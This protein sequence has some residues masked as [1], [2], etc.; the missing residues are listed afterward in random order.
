MQL[1]GS[2]AVLLYAAAEALAIRALFRPRG[3][4]GAPALVAAGLLAQFGHLELAARSLKSVPYRT[5]GGSMALFGW[6]LGIAYLVLVFRHRER[7]VGPFLIPFVLAFSILGVLLPSHPAPATSATRGSLF[8]FHVT[9]AILAYAAF[10]LS[11]V[12]SML[13]LI[14]NRQIRRGRTGVLFSRLPALEVI[15]KMNRTSVTIGILVLS[16]S[17]ALGVAW[18]HR[19]WTGLV[20]AKLVWA[21]ITLFVYGLLLWMDRRGWEGPRVALLSIVG[22]ILVLFSYTF[23]NLYLSQSHVFR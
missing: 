5:L 11:F 3:L 18:A 13:Y 21:L 12:L 17:V 2:V 23:V 20:D 10:A 7:A 4:G 22:F 8:A 16:I 9:L 15:G 6:M 14:Q 1:L 19:V